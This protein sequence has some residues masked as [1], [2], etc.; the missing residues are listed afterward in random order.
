MDNA[1]DPMCRRTFIRT[2]GALTVLAAVRSGPAHA[3]D[4]AA[5]APRL[6]IGLLGGSH[7]HGLSKAK[8]LRAS[9]DYELVGVCEEDPKVRS[10]Y[11]ALGIPLLNQAELLANADV[12]AVESGNADHARHARAVL[13]A[14]KHL[15]LEKPPTT[16]VADFRQLLGLAREQK[17]LMQM[18]YMW[19]Y[20]PGLNACLD[21][22]HRGWLGEVYQ[23]RATIDTNAGAE[24]RQLWAPFRGGIFFELG[25]H[26]VDPLIR[27]LGRPEKLQGTFQRLGEDKLVDNTQV[28]F[29]FPRALG[30]V[31]SAARQPQAQAHRTFEVLGTNGRAAVKPIEPPTLEID[32]QKAAGPYAAGKQI[33]PLPRYER[34]APEL[35]DLAAAIRAHRP[36]AVT[37]AEDLLVHESFLRACELDQ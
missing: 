11:E 6:K 28:T 35:A 25:C 27:L 23:V 5:A 19:R 21:A 37:P 22:A 17:R 36:L 33:V 1:L 24:A 30:I 13:Q 12:V 26:V 15:H 31:S 32:L 7:S 2:A 18:G 20:H 8:V 34:Y 9:T 3:A 4:A 29:Q 14:G 16:T 10:L